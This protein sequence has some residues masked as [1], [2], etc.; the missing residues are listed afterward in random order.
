[1][2]SFNE[3]ESNFSR[4]GKTKELSKDIWDKIVYL[5]KI[6][7]GYKTIG[8]QFGERGSTVGTIRKWK[9]HQLSINLPWSGAPCKDM[10]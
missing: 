1:M 5:H 7:I 3:T 4:M 8:K 10:E 6:E 9:K 2:E